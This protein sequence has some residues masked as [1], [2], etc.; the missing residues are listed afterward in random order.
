MS[1]IVEL[2]P[3]VSGRIAAGEVI[4]RPASALKELLE[5]SLDAGADRVEIALEKGGAQSMEVRDNGAGIHAEDLPLA[6]RR[7]ATSKTRSAE[8]LLAISTLGFRGEALASL[9]AAAETTIVSRTAEESHGWRYAP[10]QD[11]PP[12]P[13]AAP[14]GAKITARNLFANIPARRRFLR[15]AGTESAHCVVAVQRAAL[16]APAVSFSLTTDGRPRLNLEK[17]PNEMERLADLFPV[18]RDNLLEVRENAGPLKLHGAIFAPS[19]GASGK[20]IGQFFYVNGRFVRDRVLKR[21]VSDALRD[22]SHNGEPG[23]A[24]F[25]TLPPSAVDVNAHP[26]KLEARFAEPGAV[27]E[28][29]RRAVGKV[30][31][32]PLGAPLRDA[33]FSPADSTFRRPSNEQNEWEMKK[34]ASGRS[35]EAWRRMFSESESEFPPTMESDSTTG[36]FSL[37]GTDDEPLGRAIGM[38]HDIYIVAENR[39]GLVVIDMHAAHERIL[40]EALKRSADAGQTRTQPLLTPQRT[41]LT[42]VQAATLRE[43]AAT[44]AAVGVEARL[45]G[46]DEG[47]ILSAPLEI[48]GRADPGRLLAEMLDDLAEFGASEQATV[49]RDRALSTMAC[50]AAVRANTRLSAAEMNALLRQMETTERSGACNHGRPCWQQI[51]RAYFD[52][53]FRR[54]R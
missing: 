34:D 22:L 53:M 12:S 52:R 32:K 51:D 23:W 31:A 54:G 13:I 25:L 5:N 28:F 49:L 36:E 46:E 40:F 7:H 39:A 48:S 17:R 37:D 14:P 42:P 33:V 35:L 15:G 30:V 21:A 3:S 8:D 41:P 29:M 43:N 10:G 6:F 16:S 50:H 19:L 26:A 38:M 44:L 1:R 47:E 18:L 9:S 2:P 45:S 24:L 27:F 4:E 11:S 20:N